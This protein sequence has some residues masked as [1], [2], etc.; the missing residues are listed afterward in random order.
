VAV[1]H[2]LFRVDPF[3]IAKCLLLGQNDFFAKVEKE[4]VGF[5]IFVILSSSV[6][7]AFRRYA[8]CCKIEKNERGGCQAHAW[9]FP[10]SRTELARR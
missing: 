7:G 3:I 4:S 6:V 2:H 5:L 10:V 9:Q 8:S 1:A